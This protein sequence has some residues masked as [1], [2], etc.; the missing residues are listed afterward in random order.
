MHKVEEN[1][2]IK[3]VSWLQIVLGVL[4]LFSPW[5]LIASS[6][7]LRTT[8]LLH[9]ESLGVI[10]YI[11]ITFGFLLLGAILVFKNL[12]NKIAKILISILLPVYVVFSSLLFLMGMQI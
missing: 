12:Y 7:K 4:L 1:S 11:A 6:S 8:L 10:I 5:L 3:K 2:T 9:M